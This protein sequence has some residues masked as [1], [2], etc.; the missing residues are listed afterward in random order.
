[1]G[2]PPTPQVFWLNPC[3]NIDHVLKGIFC[4]I[5]LIDFLQTP[6]NLYMF[7]HKVG[8]KHRFLRCCFN[9]FFKSNIIYTFFNVKLDPKHLFLLCVQYSNIPNPLKT[10]VFAFY[11]CIFVRFSVA[12]CLPSR[13][14]RCQKPPKT[15]QNSISI[16][17]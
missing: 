15:T 12:G 8:S 14:F 10:S 9:H 17:S 3:K 13:F 2:G 7:G 6:R 4:N 5:F 1:M 11:F 16:P